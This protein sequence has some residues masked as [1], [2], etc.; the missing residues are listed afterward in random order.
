MGGWLGVIYSWHVNEFNFN[1]SVYLINYASGASF[2]LFL[3]LSK[4]GCMGVRACVRPYMHVQSL[5]RVYTC[6][7]VCVCACAR[8]RA[9]MI[10]F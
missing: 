8:V 10:S 9:R 3:F 6:V 2:S 1:L 4:L 5:V 7:C